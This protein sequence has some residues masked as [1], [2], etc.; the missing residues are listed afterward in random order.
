M[1][2]KFVFEQDLVSECRVYISP[3]IPLKHLLLH[4]PVA[5][6]PSKLIQIMAGD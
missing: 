1:T 6:M 4:W 5:Y 3:A 2:T